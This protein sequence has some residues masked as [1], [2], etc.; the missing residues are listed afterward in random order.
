M[1][2]VEI[3][4]FAE[5]DNAELAVDFLRSHGISAM[6]PPHQGIGG[7][8][9]AIGEASVFVDEAQVAAAQALLKRVARGDFDDADPSEPTGQSLGA[10]L[11]RALRPTPGFQKPTAWV[12][13]APLIAIVAT[14]LLVFFGRLAF[15][16][17][18]S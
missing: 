18:A 12:A 2:Q 13:L 4:R 17:F 6:M 10:A 16:Y 9:N 11:A 7:V 14:V 8:R 3:A 5:N 1:A 15:Q